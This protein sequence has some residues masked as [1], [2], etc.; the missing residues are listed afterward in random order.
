MAL[1][2]WK[3][4]VQLTESGSFTRA[5]EELQI[6]QQT[7][8]SRLAALE[9]GLG[10][11]LVVRTTPLALTR[12]GE[13]FLEYARKADSERTA[14]LRQLGDVAGGGSGVLKVGISNMRGQVLMPHVM[15]QFHRS[16]PGVSVRLLEGTNE[17]LVRMTERGEVDLAVALFD[18]AH[19]G[20]TVRR[21]FREEVVCAVHPKLLAQTWDLPSDTACSLALARGLEGLRDLPFL[22]ESIDDISGRIARIELR[23]TQIKA[24]GLVESN[25]MMTLLELCASAVGCVFCPTN[26]LDAT[27]PMTGELLRVRLSDAA[28]YDIGVG[29]PS[30]AGAW[31]PAQVFEDV[32]G[33]LYGD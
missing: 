16:L 12:A 8:S 14:M 11:R 17:E 22:L 29:M 27:E 19:P 26:L 6:S 21:I 33:A 7:L 25:N 15:T 18:N 9:R 32:L 31:T 10:C 5:S 4:L 2:S 30:D 13:V 28:R 23:R 3:W 24:K 20:V 1:E